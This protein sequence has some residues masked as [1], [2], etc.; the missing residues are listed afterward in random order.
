MSNLTAMQLI[1][2]I[3]EADNLW[4]SMARSEVNV[5]VSG[6]EGAYR[7]SAVLDSGQKHP[8]YQG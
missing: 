1:K 7:P 4:D 2:Q 8:G 3:R 6:A 5:W